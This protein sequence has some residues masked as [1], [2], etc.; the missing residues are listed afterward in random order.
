MLR[1]HSRNQTSYLRRSNEVLV[2]HDISLSF[3]YCSFKTKNGTVTQLSIFS[4]R[5]RRAARRLACSKACPFAMMRYM[6]A[7]GSLRSIDQSNYQMTAYV[8][9]L[10]PLYQFS[11]LNSSQWQDLIDTV[12]YEFR[13]ITDGNLP[14]LS[15][16]PCWTLAVRCPPPSPPR[17]PSRTRWTA[18]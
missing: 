14:Y 8:K 7:Y 2:K 6:V 16:S 9:L 17:P 1:F 10:I 13:S 12:V 4:A 18:Q 5:G 15:S 3:F 11:F